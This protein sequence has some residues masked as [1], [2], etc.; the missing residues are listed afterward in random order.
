MRRSI[1][2]TS[3]RSTTTITLCSLFILVALSLDSLRYYERHA[4]RPWA[5]S[6]DI[7]PVSKS[8]KT[9]GTDDDEE[10]RETTLVSTPELSPPHQTAKKNVTVEVNQTDYIYQRCFDCAPVVVESHKLI[11]FTIPKVSCSVWKQLFRRMEGFDDWQSGNVDLLHNPQR[12]GL[13][14]LFHYSLEEATN[15][16][17]DP[18]WTKAMFVRDPK[19]RFLSAFQ[20]KGVRES[21]YVRTF[22]CHRSISC[23]PASNRTLEAFFHLTE[24]CK[25]H[26]WN[27]MSNRIESKYMPLIN[28]LG[29]L[30]HVQQDAKALLERVGAWDE[31]GASG[32]GKNGTERIFESKSSVGHAA[33][34]DAKSRMSQHYTPELE[35]LVDAR[36]SSDYDMF[37]LPRTSIYSQSS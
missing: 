10:D 37:H 29:T 25:D 9:I 5:S 11:F 16:L 18:A 23:W 8:S 17:N 3:R 35:R 6:D 20:D 13:R 26:H 15:L 28:F 12:N 21:R 1:Q 2:C 30:E 22:C 36:F 27:P 32:W 24:T 31:Y 33:S 19:S 14:Y 34:G 4:A 7:L